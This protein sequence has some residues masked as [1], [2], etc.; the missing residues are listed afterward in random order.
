MDYVLNILK[1]HSA[2]IV[3]LILVLFLFFFCELKR[4]RGSETP[5][6]FFKE[7]VPFSGLKLYCARSISEPIKS[8]TSDRL[9]GYASDFYLFKRVDSVDAAVECINHFYR[10]YHSLR[11]IEK[12]LVIRLSS[13]ID[14]QFVEE[15][16]DRFQDI[17]I[18]RQYISFRF[19]ACRSRRTRNC[20]STPSHCRLQPQGLRKVAIFYRGN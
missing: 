11:Y 18:R 14:P 20:Q 12:Q 6:H 10:R 1:N 2:E 4:G 19:F 13:G 9:G 17:L 7:T 16:K 15:L 3:F 5:A 8:L